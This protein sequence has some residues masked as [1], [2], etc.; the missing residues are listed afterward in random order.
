MNYKK[1]PKK[2]LH[3]QGQYLPVPAEQPHQFC[4]WLC[5]LLGAWFHGERARRGCLG[6]G[7]L[8]FD[9]DLL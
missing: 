9:I 4:S 1:K 6:C 8:R 5:H 7:R 2:N 3:S